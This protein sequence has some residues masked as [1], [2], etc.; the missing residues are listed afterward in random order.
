MSTLWL[1][2]VKLLFQG[3][4]DNGHEL[5]SCELQTVF[6]DSSIIPYVLDFHLKLGIL[7]FFPFGIQSKIITIYSNLDNN[8][9]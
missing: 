6:L 2:E 5:K 7:T 3:H 9:R 4:T 8:L 1:I